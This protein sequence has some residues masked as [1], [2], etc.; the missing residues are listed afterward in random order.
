MGYILPSRADTRGDRSRSSSSNK[1]I[2]K[3]TQ[4]L[5]HGV[6][7]GQESRQSAHLQDNPDNSR[8]FKVFRDIHKRF[9]LFKQK[10]ELIFEGPLE[11]TEEGKKVRLL[12]LWVGD[13]GLEIYNT[14]I[15]YKRTGDSHNR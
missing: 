11:K 12:L 1:H 13:K 7:S 9:K 4:H 3:R 15:K 8:K 2:N 10:C 5:R 14:T 6:R